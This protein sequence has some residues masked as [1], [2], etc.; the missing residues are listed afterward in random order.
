MPRDCS[1]DSATTVGGSNSQLRWFLELLVCRTWSSPRIPNGAPCWCLLHQNGWMRLA[2]HVAKDQKSC[3]PCFCPNITSKVASAWMHRQH[4]DQSQFGFSCEE[5]QWFTNQKVN[6]AIRF[7]LYISHPKFRMKGFTKNPSNLGHVF[8]GVHLPLVKQELPFRKRTSFFQSKPYA[9]AGCKKLLHDSHGT[10]LQPQHHIQ[11]FEGSPS[12]THTKATTTGC[13][14]ESTVLVSKL[15]MSL[16]FFNFENKQWVWV[17]FNYLS[18][19]SS[20]A[21]EI[22]SIVGAFPLG[23]MRWRPTWS[24][25]MLVISG[26]ELGWLR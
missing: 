16:S 21:A 1:P 25:H 5:P 26:G 20:T 9:F 3:C 11:H 7:F 10:S 13:R 12:S 22:S 14:P 2:E 19:A 4:Q 23:L 6:F 18:S 15:T 24:C 8:V 17:F